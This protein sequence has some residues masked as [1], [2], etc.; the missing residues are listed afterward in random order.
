MVFIQQVVVKS[1]RFRPQPPFLNC[2]FPL[3]SRWIHWPLRFLL[4]A[5]VCPLQDLWISFWRVWI[6]SIWRIFDLSKRWQDTPWFAIEKFARFV[7]L[8]FELIGVYWI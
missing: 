7:F 6:W 3:I 2:S 4:C 8:G 1:G 5:L